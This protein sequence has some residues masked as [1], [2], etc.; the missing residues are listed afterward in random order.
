[1][2]TRVIH[3]PYMW[4]LR[5][6]REAPTI[7]LC[8]RLLDKSI[9]LCYHVYMRVR[10]IPTTQR[11]YAATCSL[12][13]V[14][15]TY[16]PTRRCKSNVVANP[17]IHGT[18]MPEP[19]IAKTPPPDLSPK[20]GASGGFIVAPAEGADP[21][22]DPDVDSTPDWMSQSILRLRESEI[23]LKIDE[24]VRNWEQMG[25]DVKDLVARLA[26]RLAVTQGR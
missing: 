22:I 13:T 2:Y 10:G 1:M 23:N 24:V 12:L 5:R 4:A 3:T 25:Y 14:L 18:V 26:E 21:R 16:Q 6:A 11:A 19:S 7:I 15:L 8:P 17:Y 20:T 9:Y